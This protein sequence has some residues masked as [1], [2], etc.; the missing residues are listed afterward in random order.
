MNKWEWKELDKYTKRNRN[1]NKKV[2]TEE[3]WN[4]EKVIRREE[5]GNI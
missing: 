5:R 2:K 1:R 4:I 3:K